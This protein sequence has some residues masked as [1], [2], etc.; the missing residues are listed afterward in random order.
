MSYV[1]ETYGEKERRKL[2]FKLMGICVK[3]L[4]TVQPTLEAEYSGA[5][6]RDLAGGQMGCRC[7]EVLGIDV[8]LD[9][10]LK[11]Y[12]IEVNHLPSFTA[13]SP[14]DD[15]IKR[16]LIDQTL[17]IT[18]G[19]L[20]TK[21][22]KAYEQLVRERRDGLLGACEAKPG[23]DVGLLVGCPKDHCS[24]NALDGRLHFFENKVFLA[25]AQD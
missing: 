15:D 16:R 6:P 20:S 7:F 8:M 12:L 23:E 5:F 22:K 9:A 10:K 2:W 18:C 19:S 24:P 14:L 17:D 1:G 25:L 21:D 3:T 4:L 11:P 13:D